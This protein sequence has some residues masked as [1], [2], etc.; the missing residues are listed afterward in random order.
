MQLTVQSLI[1]RGDPW[2]ESIDR[3]DGRS[4]GRSVSL[5]VCFP[6]KK[7]QGEENF[8]FFCVLFD[9]EGQKKLSTVKQ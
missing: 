2:M 5:L 6:P 8:V 4:L 3:L 9:W 1:S 7:K